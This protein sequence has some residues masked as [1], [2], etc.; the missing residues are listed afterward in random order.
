M[1][2]VQTCALPIWTAGLVAVTFAYVLATFRLSRSAERSAIAAERAAEA[3][4]DAAAAQRAAVDVDFQVEC[5]LVR[6]RDDEAEVDWGS[7]RVE[8]LSASVFVHEVTLEQVWSDNRPTLNRALPCP[9]GII[10]DLPPVLQH[11]G[12]AT[13]W[14]WPTDIPPKDAWSSFQVTYSFDREGERFRR[15]RSGKLQWI[16][17]TAP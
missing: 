5:I 12:E 4:R 1:T 9:L 8:S 2:G 13:V 16:D 3:A 14:Q 7:V 10:G 17:A 6:R 15:S 11:R